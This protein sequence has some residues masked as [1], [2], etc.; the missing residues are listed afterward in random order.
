MSLAIGQLRLRD[1]M[2]ELRQRMD[3]L[4]EHWDDAAAREFDAEVVEPLGE[5]VQAALSA[6]GKMQGLLSSARRASGADGG[7]VL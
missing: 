5:R 2:K 3:R 7:P 4:R 6:A 1:A